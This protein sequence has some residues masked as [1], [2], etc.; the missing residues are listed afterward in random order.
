MPT[1]LLPVTWDYRLQLVSLN[2]KLNHTNIDLNLIT[3]KQLGFEPGSPGPKA[4]ALPLCYSI[5][6]F[7]ANMSPSLFSS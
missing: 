1:R 4:A 6:T 3:A 7:L 5:D 2:H